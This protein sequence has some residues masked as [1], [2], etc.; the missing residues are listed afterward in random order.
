MCVCACTRRSEENFQ[1]LVLFFHGAFWGSHSE[2]QTWQPVPLLT[3]PSCWSRTVVLKL[4]YGLE[5]SS[6]LVTTPSGCNFG[7]IP[8]KLLGGSCWEHILSKGVA[9]AARCLLSGKAA[10]GAFARLPH[11]Q[12]CD[13]GMSLKFMSFPY[14]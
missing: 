11:P 7:S 12:F 5:S 9:E 6:G 13:P 4:E 2:C 14:L 10:W 8:N 1:K 3:E